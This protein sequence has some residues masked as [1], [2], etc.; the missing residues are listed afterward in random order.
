MSSK[1]KKDQDDLNAKVLHREMSKKSRQ[2]AAFG[3]M[4][5]IVSFIL[6][7]ELETTFL[8]VLGKGFV[9][10]CVV[11]PWAHSYYGDEKRFKFR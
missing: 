9:A 6:L 1:L 5:L 11:I 3:L 10:A 2:V 7:T 4:F 8:Y